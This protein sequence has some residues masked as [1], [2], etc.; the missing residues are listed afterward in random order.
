MF[1]L[2]WHLLISCSSY[3]MFLSI[4]L[5]ECGPLLSLLCA[6][7]GP[8]HPQRLTGHGPGPQQLAG[9]HLHTR[10]DSWQI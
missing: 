9:V 7:A 5:N 2:A 3:L 8:D 1:F 10:G 6:A 4:N